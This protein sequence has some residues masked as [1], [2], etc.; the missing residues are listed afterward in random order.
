MGS[1]LDEANALVVLAALLAAL[2]L[3]LPPVGGVAQWLIQRAH[4]AGDAKG[5]DVTA[6]A[7]LPPPVP[8]LL[9]P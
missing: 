3:L 8:C 9:P 5:L 1:T 4:F 2:V 6:D 7:A